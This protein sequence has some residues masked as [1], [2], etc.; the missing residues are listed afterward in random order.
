MKDNNERTE[1]ELIEG[2]NSVSMLLDNNKGRRKIF[3]LYI[4]QSREDDLKIKGIKYKAAEKHISF[5]VL[6]K[7]DFEKILR[8][9]PLKSQ[10]ICAK[11]SN[12]SYPDIEIFLRDRPDKKTRLLILDGITDVGNF[13]GIIRSAFAFDFDGI[14]IPKHRSADVNRDVNRASSGA[15]EGVSIFRV[16]NLSRIIDML[17]SL[18]FW[19]YGT[20]VYEEDNRKTLKL[21]ET[22]FNFPMALILGGEHK[23]I[24]RLLKDKSDELVNIEINGRLDSLNV[25]VSAGILLYFINRQAERD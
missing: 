19:I 25:S 1:F 8:T 12:Y 3:N 18:G 6:P 22:I 2:I 24:S 5:S 20:S 7:K 9:N 14:I 10:G 4:L 13:G 17:K 16:S 11:V 21:S 15:L 23:G